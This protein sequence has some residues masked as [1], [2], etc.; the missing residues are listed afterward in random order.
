MLRMLFITCKLKNKMKKVICICAS[1]FLLSTFGALAPGEMDAY[2]FSQYDISGTARYMSMGGAFGALGGDI[3]SMRTNPAGL[4]IYRSSEVLTTMSLSS[5]KAKTNWVGTK[6][7]DSKTK[8]NFDNIAYVGYFPTGNDEGVIGWNV[9]FAY[10][11]EKSFDRQYRMGRGSGGYSL[12]DYIAAVTNR[13]GATGNQLNITDSNDP[14]QSQNW[15]SVMG[16]NIYMIDSKDQSKGGNFFSQFGQY[17][18]KGTW[19]NWPV[20]TSDLYVRERGSIDKYDFS[21]ATNISNKIFLGAGLAVTDITYRMNSSYDEDF[22]VATNSTQTKSDHLFMDNY[23]SVDGTGYGFNLGV[24]ARPSDYLR[25]GVAYNSPTWYKLTN[26]YSAES[27]TRIHDYFTDKNGNKTDLDKTTHTDDKVYTDYK[28]HSP[29]RWIFSV[30][31]ILGQ[32]ALISVDYELTNYKNMRLYNYAG[33][34]MVDDNSYIKSDF[35]S[36]GMLKAGAEIKFTPQFAF[37]LGGAWQSTSMK[38]DTKN[39]LVEIATAGTRTA[40]T[41]DYHTTYYTAGIGYRFTPNFYTDL[42]CVYRMQKENAY[43]FSN[44]FDN[45]GSVVVASDPAELKTNTFKVALTLGYKF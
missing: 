40:Y 14:Y 16:Y 34:A 33:D 29:D 24:I 8:F 4:G 41:V 30:A 26:Y 43:A 23:S 21:F 7:D 22:G 36:S 20:Q 13:T 5:V 35:M 39:G 18:N 6:M 31:G 44:I 9:G 28:M 38:D 42:A 45:K 10:N 37:R 2:K 11:R 3:S 1:R 27:G 19:E 25:V 17:N 12:S 32:T 15:L